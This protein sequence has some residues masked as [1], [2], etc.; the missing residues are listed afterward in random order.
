[1]WFLDGAKAS[2]FFALLQKVYE[3]N[4]ENPMGGKENSIRDGLQIINS[5]LLSLMG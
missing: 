2:S 4:K 5:S 3:L 1:M